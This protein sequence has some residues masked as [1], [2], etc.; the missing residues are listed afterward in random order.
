MSSSPDWIQF[1][2]NLP[3]AEEP[4][5]RF[6][7]CS[8]NAH[9]LSGII[10]E[11][12]GMSEQDYANGSLFEPLGISNVS[13]PSDPQGNNHGWGDLR[14]TP[15]DMAKLGYLYLNEGVWDGKQVVP[16]EWVAESTQKQVSL[17]EGEGYGYQWWVSGSVPGIY[18][19]NGR[20]GQR[21]IV[22]PEKN[23]ILVTT[24][25]GFEPDEL[26]PFLLAALKSD[27]SLP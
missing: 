21:I 6:V 24:G 9:L 25:G 26:S 4:G 11:T 15:Y 3:M 5:T 12:T 18:E 23:I 8:N 17:E 1:T 27:Q 10:R 7:Y 13:W 14:L 22:W 16:A 20:G 19:A 2:L